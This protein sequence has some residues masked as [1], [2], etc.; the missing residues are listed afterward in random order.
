MIITR[1]RVRALGAELAA[2]LGPAP[3]LP[4]R[5]HSVFA[6][7]VNF[8][9]ADGAL[10]TLQE[11]GPIAAPFSAA[12]TSWGADFAG[13]ALALDLGGARRVDLTVRPARNGAEVAC[14]VIRDALAAIPGLRGAAGLDSARGRAARV[15]LS[16]A[17]QRR[18]A[19]DFLDAARALIGLGEGLTPAGDDFLVGSLAILH[20]LTDGWP[21]SAAV[22][23]ALTAH[24]VHAS[25]TVGAAFLR[26]AVAGQFSEPLRDLAMAK[27]P[28]AARAAAA[29]LA[30]MGATS[31]ADTLAG[32]RAALAALGATSA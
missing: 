3:C 7:A 17:V 24:A 32:M 6:R 8:E 28:S 11:A 21:G 31:G 16:R 23:P 2:R 25:T 22:A 5:P 18:D 15:A 27:T 14:T 10:L 29:T 20:R 4:G 12:L 26:H 30:R 13:G 1:L 19:A 9:A